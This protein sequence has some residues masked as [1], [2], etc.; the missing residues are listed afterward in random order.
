MHTV[1]E[2][3]KQEG[4][5]LRGALFLP[6]MGVQYHFSAFW[7]FSA[8][9]LYWEGAENSRLSACWDSSGCGCERVPRVGVSQVGPGWSRWL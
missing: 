9:S 7:F 1:Q 5:R 3:Q 8:P 6:S 2:K 4:T